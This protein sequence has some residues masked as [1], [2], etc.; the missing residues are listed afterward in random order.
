MADGDPW[1][2]FSN[3]FDGMKN[4][5]SSEERRE[6]SSFLAILTERRCSVVLRRPGMADGGSWWHFG[7]EAI[8]LK[9]IWA[10]MLFLRQTSLG[11][12]RVCGF[13]T[14][15]VSF[16]IDFGRISSLEVILKEGCVCS[17]LPFGFLGISLSFRG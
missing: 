7:I 10:E 12:V 17:T 3:D 1:W 8:H 13:Y 5:R 15:P 11:I 6:I 2:C 9:W 4:R 16:L 14:F